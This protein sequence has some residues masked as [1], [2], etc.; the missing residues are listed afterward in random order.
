MKAA[1]L[2]FL[3][4]FKRENSPM[5][6]FNRLNKCGSYEEWLEHIAKSEAGEVQGRLPSA[7]FFGVIQDTG[8]IAGIT[9][10]RFKLVDSPDHLPSYVNGHLGGSIR[11]ALRG[12]GYSAQMLRLSLNKA[13]EYGLRRVC[14]SCD[15]WN[16][17]SE[18]VIV[19]CG[20][21]FDNEITEQDYNVVRRF[22]FDIPE[23]GFET[24]L[25]N[26]R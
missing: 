14:V 20:G 17:A 15:K 11:P 13:A 26:E 25:N 23:N 2:E 12:R 22:W 6:G 24:V 16:A 3:E 8:E 1:A 7:S 10:V 4:E 21:V 19:K 5:N 18:H 9:N